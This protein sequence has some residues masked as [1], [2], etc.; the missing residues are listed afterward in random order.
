MN[1]MNGE[2]LTTVRRV[3]QVIEPEEIT[4]YVVEVQ[5]TDGTWTEETRF[6]N[7]Y[8][9][10]SFAVEPGIYF[11]EYDDILEATQAAENIAN[12]TGRP[13]RIVEVT[14]NKESI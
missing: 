1:F 3:I 6:G 8:G 12:N 14:R 11:E 10:G 4:T 2:S 5:G 13:A 7:F 9:P